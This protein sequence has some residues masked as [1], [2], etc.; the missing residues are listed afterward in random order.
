M[1]A[2][3]SHD[4]YRKTGQ[5]SL[6]WWAKQSFPRAPY[7]DASHDFHLIIIVDH[8]DIRGLLKRI[9][10]AIDQGC[11]SQGFSR[12]PHSFYR[13]KPHLAFEDDTS[14][15][16]VAARDI[17]A[18]RQINATTGSSVHS[19]QKFSTTFNKGGVR[20]TGTV[21]QRRNIRI[22]TSLASRAVVPQGTIASI[23]R[24]S[25]HGPVKLCIFADTLAPIPVIDIALA[26]HHYHH[27]KE[28]HQVTQIRV[29]F[30]AVQ[31]QIGSPRCFPGGSGL[32][33]V[34]IFSILLQKLD[35]F[36]ERV[37]NCFLS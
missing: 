7:S 34:G 21:V 19:A 13:T 33:F 22:Q 35:V 27:S 6:P 36:E 3:T 4:K 23:I 17:F 28:K 15:T 12:N 37:L 24:G 32:G 16:R 1:N 25:R 9:L 5:F 10:L 30:C 11:E 26:V 8:P 2:Y 29:Y 31:R 18:G 20:D 14:V